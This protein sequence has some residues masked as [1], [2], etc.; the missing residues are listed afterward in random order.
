M[1]TDVADCSPAELVDA[2]ARVDERDFLLRLAH[3][4]ARLEESQEDGPLFNRLACALLT[5]AYVDAVHVGLRPN[6]APP[7]FEQLFRMANGAG[8]HE[9]LPDELHE[10]N[11]RLALR[12]IAQHEPYL[13]P[14][15]PAI[16]RTEILL[17][18]LLP[19]VLRGRPNPLDELPQALGMRGATFE[20]VRAVT[21]GLYAWAIAQGT[22]QVLTRSTL[23]KTLDAAQMWDTANALAGSRVEL[24]AR[25][26]LDPGY[27][28]PERDY[29]Y[30]YSV[31][32]DVPLVRLT[33]ESLVAPVARHLAL[34]FSDGVFNF[35]GAHFRA[36]NSAAKERFDHI[37]GDVAD[38]YVRERLRRDL[39]DGAYRPLP[40]VRG[41]LSPDGL[42]AD[43]DCV[44]EVKGKRLLRGIAT[45][46]DLA[47]A[48]G[49]IGGERGLG[50]G[51]AQL[52]A[53]LARTRAGR[54]RGLDASRVDEAVPCLVTPDGFPG[55][56]FTPVRRGLLALFEATVR[57][58][59]PDVVTE[60]PSLE[61][62]E[63]LSFDQLDRVS[64]ASRHSGVSMGRVL[65][66]FRLECPAR[67]VDGRTNSLAPDLR[68]WLYA[69]EPRSNDDEWLSAAFSSAYSD[70]AL[71]MFGRGLPPE[72]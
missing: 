46:G 44:F 51:V 23:S 13:G 7:P 15:K 59:F 14:L 69:R 52:L 50:R 24:A 62:F 66:R 57:E 26:A 71:R 20:H 36:A 22:S 30:A 18:R 47:A 33:D 48:P 21:L 1:T 39:G 12:L 37:F 60:L 31:L 43:G 29:R 42:L 49:Y 19:Q 25:K 56:H 32:R 28:A 4:S 63:W 11:N 54:G 5:V 55:F 38:A 17:G 72:P 53:E 27:G 16:G 2:L 65:R 58:H 61:R 40:E 45:T 64:R 70:S 68:D 10:S 3:V 34:A 9:P 8:F 6:E 41:Q 35:L 67:P